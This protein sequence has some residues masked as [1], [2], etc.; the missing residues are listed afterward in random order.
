MQTLL[1][2]LGVARASA[3]EMLRTRRALMLALLYALG[4]GAAAFVFTAAVREVVGKLGISELPPAAKE[5]ASNAYRQIAHGLSGAEG[6]DLTRLVA[7]PPMALFWVWVSLWSTPLL[8]TIASG[9]ALA[10]TVERGGARFWL[11]RTS[12]LSYGLGW[13]L[14]QWMFHGAALAISA[15]V[16]ALVGAIR[17]PQFP[18]GATLAAEL[19][20]LPFLAC[21]AAAFLA[22]VQAAGQLGKTS[23]MGRAL[24]IFTLIALTL[25]AS[26]KGVA[27]VAHLGDAVAALHF[28]S[29]FSLWRQG[30]LPGFLATLAGC[31]GGVA[32]ASVF[33]L[34]G[35]LRFR[36]RDL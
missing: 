11:L 1:D 5:L 31:A 19:R 21:Y 35:H 9:D 29:P 26:L 34:L 10:S 30:F 15:L 27:K 28:L 20:F 33:F 2:A 22:A 8:V 17:L 23:V 16:A 13:G 32:Y 6:E 3:L 12:R 4:G 14:G 7:E 18:L 25:L 36:S 24:G